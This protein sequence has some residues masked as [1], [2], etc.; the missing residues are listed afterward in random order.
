[1]K[2]TDR[3]PQTDLYSTILVYKGKV[4]FQREG[5]E[6]RKPIRDIRHSEADWTRE[7]SA[8]R[9]TERNN[10]VFLPRHPRKRE[11][12]FP[13]SMGRNLTIDEL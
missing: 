9:A 7:P 13:Y 11:G 3:N 12:Q 2:T 1:M 10:S 8:E 4:G 5:G 6:P